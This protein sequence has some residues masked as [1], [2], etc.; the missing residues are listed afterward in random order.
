MKRAVEAAV[1]RVL[2]PLVKL[3]LE[4][5]IG[6]G[7]LHS[8]VKRAYVRAAREQ[9]RAE[10]ERPEQPNASRIAVVT[11]LTRAEVATILTSGEDAPALSERGRQRAERVLS[12]WW[13]DPDFQD[14]SGQPAKLPLRG[15]RASF[16]ALC[17]RYSGEQR[18]APTLS[19]LLRVGA[20]RRLSDGRLQ[21]VSRTYATVR[22]DSDGIA[23]VGEQLSEHCATLVGNLEPGGRRRLA[24]RVFNARLDPRYAP[25]LI[26]DIERQ[27]EAF[28]DSVDDALND[29]QHTERPGKARTPVSRLGIGVYLYYEEPAEAPDVTQAHC[30]TGA[31]PPRAAHRVRTKK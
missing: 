22:W 12:G 31:R 4:A 13:T 25:A 15:R 14:D 28:A 23:A 6:V 1:L 30:P 3:L 7:D 27:A 9:G 18:T 26:R 10:G 24:R 29:P 16:A 19:E 2:Q 17:H 20:V 5:G 21:A 8:L 11:G